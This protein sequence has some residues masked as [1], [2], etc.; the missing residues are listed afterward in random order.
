MRVYTVVVADD[1]ADI[2]ELIAIAIERAGLRLVASVGDGESALAAIREHVPD[3]AVVDGAMP[4]L[5]GREVVRRVRA[6][7]SLAEVRTLLLSASVDEQSRQRGIDAG[8]DHFL[9]KPFSLR[10]FTEWLAVGKEPR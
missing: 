5:S 6:D 7:E 3:L 9:P 2:R 10:A 4:G 1:D 8:A